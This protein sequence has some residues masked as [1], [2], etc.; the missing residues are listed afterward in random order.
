MP[1]ALD[2]QALLRYH[3][4][5]TSTWVLN[6]LGSKAACSNHQTI[7]GMKQVV[8]GIRSSPRHKYGRRNCSGL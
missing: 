4:K 7:L 1:C 3:K 2:G 8:G 5:V 6:E